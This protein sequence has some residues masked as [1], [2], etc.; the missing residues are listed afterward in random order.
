MIEALNWII[1]FCALFGAYLNSKQDVRGFKVWIV[2]NTYLSAY[3]FL[4][5]ELAQGFLFSIY[6]VIAINGLISWKKNS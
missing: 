4:S 2:T 1:I 3:N 6:L 5:G